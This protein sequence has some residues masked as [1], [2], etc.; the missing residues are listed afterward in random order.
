[1]TYLDDAFAFSC[2]SETL[3]G[4]LSLPQDSPAAS[5]CTALVIVVGGPQYRVGSHRQFVGL[6]RS[7]AAAGIPALRF[8][9]RG[10]GDSTGA[11]CSFETIS[12]DIAAALDVLQARLPRV[13]RIALWGLCDGASAALMYWQQSHDLR[14]AALALVNPWTRSAATLAR[15]HLKHYY[16]QRLLDSSFW[17]KLLSGKV[18]GRAMRG[19]L[20]NLRTAR[21]GAP[22]APAGQAASVHLPFQERMLLGCMQFKGPQ[23]LVLSGKDYTAKEF[24]EL[25]A[26]EPRWERALER[27]SVSRV[28]VPDA[29]HTFSGQH[30]DAA[31][32]R[33]TVDWLLSTVVPEEPA[34]TPTM[35][36]D[37]RS[38]HD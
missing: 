29:D 31:L 18:G 19:L 22:R 12:D 5:W 26:S 13:K 20:D 24:L 33:A 23:L 21:S 3:V 11:L 36:I 4:V 2:G 15:A 27:S 8:D 9:C 16:M 32:R 34:P 6:A 30:D 28:D 10:M 37:A 7:A 1:M 25:I 35:T 38:A 17:A 14:V